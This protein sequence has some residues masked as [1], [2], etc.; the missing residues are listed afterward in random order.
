[1]RAGERDGSSAGK[2]VPDRTS[3]VNWRIDSRTKP[4]NG[5]VGQLTIIL[6]VSLSLSLS[7]SLVLAFSH[8][9]VSL[10]PWLQPGSYLSSRHEN[11][12]GRRLGRLA[13]ASYLRPC[14]NLA[15]RVPRRQANAL[16]AG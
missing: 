12:S 2:L 14:E 11:A 4:R 8:F 3:L 15:L 6:A 5:T 1:V 7:L 10:V 13:L 9:V 16:V